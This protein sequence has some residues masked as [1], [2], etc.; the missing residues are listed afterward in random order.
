[1]KLAI[2]YTAEFQYAQK[3]SF[4]PHLVR[5]FPRRDFSVEVSVTKFSARGAAD[6]QYRTDLFGNLIAVCFFP[7]PQEV[8]R[9]SLDLELNLR[10][11]NPFHFL[12]EGYALKLPLEYR[13]EEARVLAPF[14]EWGHDDFDLPPEFR[15]PG[16]TPTLDALVAWNTAAHKMIAY[17]RREEGDPFS[18]AE[19]LSR[20]SGSCRDTA[21]LFA[22]ILRRH[23][24]AARLVSG[25]LWET[26][27]N[28]AER[29]AENALH[30]WVE[31]YLPGAGWVG[32]DPTNGVFA[33]HH[34]IPAAAGLL[35]AQIAP[36]QGHYY[37]KETIPSR[38]EAKLEIVPA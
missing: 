13:A 24:I 27:E 19:T 7:D 23:G 11:S 34:R 4:S 2:H 6:T 8:L 1:M 25:Y 20:R 15:C 16:E 21:V 17:E 33:D 32:M 35:H 9:F 30:A 18:P 12:L 10:E 36:I 14:L 29:R 28:P 37:G 26:S 5:L 31:A 3:A 22:E 38:L